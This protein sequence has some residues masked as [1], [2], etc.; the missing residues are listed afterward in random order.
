MDDISK[1]AEMQAEFE[2]KKEESNNKI[3]ELNFEMIN[4]RQEIE[5]K[6][7]KIQ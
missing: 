7:N 4:A 2:T 1:I 6:T 3:E 5:E